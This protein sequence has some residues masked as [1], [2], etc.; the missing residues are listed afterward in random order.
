M[1][2]GVSFPYYV[3]NPVPPINFL[4]DPTYTV[5]TGATA[6]RVFLQANPASAYNVNP[7]ILGMERESRVVNP[8][9][10]FPRAPL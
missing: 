10:P 5:F 4:P 8:P 2:P 7:I 9:V 1:Q 3:G 6:I